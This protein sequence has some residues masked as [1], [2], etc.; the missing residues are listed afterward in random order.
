MRFR[1]EPL[2]LDQTPTECL[3]TVPNMLCCMSVFAL[4][5]NIM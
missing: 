1:L 5:V 2:A 3:L 4:Y